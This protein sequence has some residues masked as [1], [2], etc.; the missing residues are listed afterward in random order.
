[1]K[2]IISSYVIIRDPKYLTLVDTSVYNT[3]LP[4]TEPLL[5]IT[6][7][8]FNKFVYVPYEPSAVNNINSHLLNL[9]SGWP[10][11]IIELPSGVYTINQSICPNDKLYVEY[12]ILNIAP[13]LNRLARAMC[14]VDCIDL[15]AFRPY[16]DL[17]MSLEIAKM[18]VETNNNVKDGVSLYNLTV[19][20]IQKLLQNCNC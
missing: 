13:D 4:I 20:K 10:G 7:P 16:Y 5:K 2:S 15:E 9:S 11:G 18:L 6:L 14:M 19:R 12:N 3:D 8:N 17:L 1:M